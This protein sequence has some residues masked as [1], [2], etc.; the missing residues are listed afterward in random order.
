MA[1]CVLS[2]AVGNMRIKVPNLGLKTDPY[3]L[4]ASISANVLAF[5][6][7]L[8]MLQIYDRV[9]PNQGVE[10]LSVLAIGVF[11][12]IVLE[13]VL[14]TARA[15]LMGLA[16]DAYERKTQDLVFQ[17]LLKSDLAKIE[18]EPPGVHLDRL[19]SI[20]RIRDFRNG[21]AAMAAL[22]MPFVVIFLAVVLVISPILAFTIVFVLGCAI[23]LVN[24]MQSKS[25]ALSEKKHEIDRRRYSFLI[26]VLNGMESIKS[27]NLEAFMERRYERLMG[28]TAEIGAEATRRSNF[29]QGITGAIGQITPVLIASVGAI[30]V[31]QQSMTVGA[32]AA[33]ILLGT[34]IVQP[35]L[36]LSSLRAGDDDTRRAENDLATFLSTP[37]AAAG[38]LDCPSLDHVSFENITF[39]PNDSEEP[40]FKG[41]D[42]QFSRGEVLV[43]DG[44]NGAGRSVLMWMLTGYL[45]P[46]SGSIR[47]NGNDIEAY[48]GV[49]LR[50]RI[51]YLPNQPTLIEG[52]VL[53]NMTRF[54]P[55]TYLEDALEVAASLG[56]DEYFATHQEGL[57]TMVGRGSD[58][59]LPTSVAE[60]VP[61]VGALV[62]HPDLVLFDEANANLD[63][64]GDRRLKEHLAALKGEAAIIMVTQRPSYAQLADRHL[65]LEN[66][67]LIDV[68][69]E[70][71]S[72]QS[73]PP[74]INAQQPVAVAS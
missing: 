21:D 41:I 7:P 64:D 40:L 22:D 58:A 65:R 20:D 33:T 25:V 31:V 50:K 37:V 73:N 18:K 74:A 57:S 2:A 4:A 54:Q 14:R 28:S 11:I 59:G 16:G 51:A 29:S 1:N 24:R 6:L 52:T 38:T 26:E 36:K 44:A 10:T 72:R 61:L 53:D 32:L 69:S 23:F 13:L 8:F 60:R 47:I 35:V 48:D 9:I 71:K 42:L 17:R 62:G 55:E 27:A 43:I 45:Q 67:R 56:L 39:M 49:S 63:A 5:A 12:A 30:L 70:V 34:R 15:Q 68:T 66:G 19:S 46:T 3:I